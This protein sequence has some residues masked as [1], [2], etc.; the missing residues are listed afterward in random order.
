MILFNTF[1]KLVAKFDKFAVICIR[2]SPTFMKQF[3]Q[4]SF[5]NLSN[6]HSMIRT[7]FIRWCTWPIFHNR[8]EG[9]AVKMDANLKEL[10]K[11][12]VSMHCS[13]PLLIDDLFKHYLDSFLIENRMWKC[14]FL[15]TTCLVSNHK[16]RLTPVLLV[17]ICAAEFDWQK[18]IAM[19]WCE[20]KYEMVAI[21]VKRV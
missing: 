7:K 5:D 1:N 13:I 15:A 2:F 19:F 21:Q 12:E 4:Y 6:I 14:L 11:D 3:K 18:S 16:K 10:V 9:L 20:C 8:I 17:L